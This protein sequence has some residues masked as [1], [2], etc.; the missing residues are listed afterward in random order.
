M[1]HVFSACAN[2]IV[3][4][5]GFAAQDVWNWLDGSVLIVW[6]LERRGRR[7]MWVSFGRC[8]RSLNKQPM[9]PSD[10]ESTTVFD[11]LIGGLVG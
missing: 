7:I 1:I 8:V 10:G 2:T 11:C 4:T 3:G 9:P 5:S 6:Y